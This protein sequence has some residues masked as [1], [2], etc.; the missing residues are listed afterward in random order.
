MTNPLLKIN[1]LKTYFHTYNGIVKAVDGVTFELGKGQTLGIVGESGCGKSV[2]SRSILRLIESPGKIESGSIHY[3]DSNL[4]T[5]SESEMNSIRGKEISIIFQDPLTSLN[6]VMKVGDQI[7]EAIGLHFDMSKQETQEKAKK[8]LDLVGIPSSEERYYDYPFTFSGGMRQRL[9]IASA[10]SCDPSI[11]IADEPTTNLD[12]TTHAHILEL[13]SELKSRLG[14]SI[15]LITHNLGVVAWLCEY[16]AVMYAG[17]I[18]E[19]GP[20]KEIFKNPQHPYT[21]AL[22]ECLITSDTSSQVDSIPGMIPD[23]INPPSGCRFH[24]RCNHAFDRCLS[25]DPRLFTYD[26]K[27]DYACWLKE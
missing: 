21:S 9:V 2:T 15:I 13:L 17:R 22:M 12:V 18:V 25:D 14:M 11:L 8:M 1:D 27:R 19:Y 6:P 10:L 24:P 26:K 5:L 16:V 20:V 4:L 3:K 7:S 23:L